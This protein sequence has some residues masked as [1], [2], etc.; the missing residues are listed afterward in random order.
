MGFPMSIIEVFS[1]MSSVICYMLMPM[2]YNIYNSL[3]L[4]L[5]LGFVLCLLGLGC[6]FYIYNLTIVAEE[7]GVIHVAL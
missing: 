3:A 7:Q 4:P 1:L 2:L 5:W 6:S